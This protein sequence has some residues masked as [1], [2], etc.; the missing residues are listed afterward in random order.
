M[1]KELVEQ[2]MGALPT[3]LSLG[4]DGWKGRS[5]HQPSTRE[6]NRDEGRDK[7]YVAKP[8]IACKSLPFVTAHA[9]V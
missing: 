6:Q 9:R 8:L 2:I 3:L 5:V 4:P 1:T 7:S